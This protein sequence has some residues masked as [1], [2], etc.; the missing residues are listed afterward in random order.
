[1]PS[2]PLPELRISAGHAR[3]FLVRNSWGARWG[4]KGYFTMPYGYLADD[5]LADDMW[6]IRRGEQM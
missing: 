5:N 3:R 2:A 1:M 6:T 4:Q